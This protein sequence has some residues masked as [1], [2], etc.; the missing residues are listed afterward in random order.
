MVP[1]ARSQWAFMRGAWG[2]LSSTFISSAPKTASTARSDV[3]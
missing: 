1:V 3:P 2:A